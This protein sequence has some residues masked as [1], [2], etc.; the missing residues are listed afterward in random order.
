MEDYTRN[1]TVVSS[2]VCD[3]YERTAN[4]ARV[5]IS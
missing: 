2:N 3:T 1:E 5:L 4:P